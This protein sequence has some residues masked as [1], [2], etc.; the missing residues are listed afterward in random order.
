MAYRTLLCGW[1]G[2]ETLQIG[3]T[4]VWH[5]AKHLANGQLLGP[6]LFLL[7]REIHVG[8]HHALL[9]NSKAPHQVIHA[10]THTHVVEMTHVNHLTRSCDSRLRFDV[11]RVQRIQLPNSSPVSTFYMPD[12]DDGGNGIIIR[13]SAMI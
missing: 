13:N 12:T 5:E 6:P 9:R 1:T 11:G 8:E 7:P 10:C 4:T 3:S 2:L